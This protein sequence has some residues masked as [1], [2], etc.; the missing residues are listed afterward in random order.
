[1]T[2]LEPAASCSQSRRATNCATPRYKTSLVVIDKLSAGY[3]GILGFAASC[4]SQNCILAI[5]SHNFDRY[6]NKSSLSLPQAAVRFVAQSRRAVSCATPQYNKNYLIILL[7]LWVFFKGVHTGLFF[8]FL[9]Y[10]S[11]SFIFFCFLC[12]SLFLYQDHIIP[13]IIP[14]P[15]TPK[16]T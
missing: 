3:R 11:F 13:P 8:V 1:M 4:G 7:C 5:R 9:N 6:A 14:T 15:R 10:L 2:G 12:Y 16:A